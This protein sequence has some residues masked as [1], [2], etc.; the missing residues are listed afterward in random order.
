MNW[1]SWNTVLGKYF[2]LEQLTQQSHQT[3]KIREYCFSVTGPLCYMDLPL[4]KPFHYNFGCILR[5][6]VLLEDLYLLTGFL[7]GLPCIYGAFS[8]AQISER[9][10]G[11][12]VT[13]E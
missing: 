5:V 4:S 11:F 1:P 2:Y 13:P 8:L 6:L 7:L 10:A 9:E 12:D 3:V